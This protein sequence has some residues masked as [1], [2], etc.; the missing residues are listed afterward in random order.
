MSTREV[1]WTSDGIAIE[2]RGASISNTAKF[3]RIHSDHFF[4]APIGSASIGVSRGR[5]HLHAQ[6]STAG[7]HKLGQSLG[8]I[9]Y[10]VACSGSATAAAVW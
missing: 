1:A 2:G 6:D 3:P 5:R 9:R 4:G 8:R 7:R 10:R